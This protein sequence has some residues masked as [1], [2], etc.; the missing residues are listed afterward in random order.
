MTHLT[1][2]EKRL[3][4][5]P[6]DLLRKVATGE[7]ELEQAEALAEGSWRFECARCGGVHTGPSDKAACSRREDSDEP[8]VLS[9]EEREDAQMETDL[10]WAKGGY[11][12]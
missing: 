1:K 11:A 9:P 4:A 12:R 2:L 3:Y 10:Y 8:Y 5:L 7:V 6:M